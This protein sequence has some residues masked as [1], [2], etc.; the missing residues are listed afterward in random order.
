MDDN[1]IRR[2]RFACWVTKTTNKQ[3]N[4]HT[5]REIPNT[6]SVFMTTVVTRTRH[7]AT[8]YVCCLSSFYVSFN[9]DAFVQQ[10]CLTW[11]WIRHVVNTLSL[12]IFTSNVQGSSRTMDKLG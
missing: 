5:H 6:Y 9:F 3:T 11:Q 7:D 2:V 12:C 10:R 4:K 8:S 1:R